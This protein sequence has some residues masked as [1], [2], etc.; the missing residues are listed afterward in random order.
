[1]SGR[2]IL[3]VFNPGTS[4]ESST[5]LPGTRIEAWGFILRSDAVNDST[6]LLGDVPSGRYMS[7]TL[8][9]ADRQDFVMLP[10]PLKYDNGLD[11][12]LSGTNASC[13]ILYRRVGG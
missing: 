11:Y 1:M 8:P 4:P 2:I 6:L 7:F 3:E 13:A 12:D 5:I 10:A 9:A